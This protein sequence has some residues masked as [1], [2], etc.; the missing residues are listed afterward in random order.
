MKDSKLL[1]CAQDNDLEGLKGALNSGA[2]INAKDEFLGNTAL[3]FAVQNNN[4]E[5]VEFLLKKGALASVEGKEANRCA[6]HLSAM[7]AGDNIDILELLIQNGADVNALNNGR[8]ALHYAAENGA[9][10]KV[11]LLINSGAKINISDSKR[12]TPLHLAVAKGYQEIADYLLKNGADFEAK[13]FF[14][15]TL[16][17]YAVFSNSADMVKFILSCGVNVEEKNNGGKTASDYAKELCRGNL[18]KVISDFE[19]IGQPDVKYAGSLQPT[20]GTG[21]RSSSHTDDLSKQSSSWNRQQ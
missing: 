3:C 5:M 18:V 7:F 9:G 19:K 2:N 17:H 20:Q 12:E 6:V 10:K 15:K 11:E 21:E 8:T 16:L 13:G 1:K 14:G 4:K